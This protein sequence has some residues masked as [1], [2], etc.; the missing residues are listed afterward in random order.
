[1]ETPWYSSCNKDTSS[2]GQARSQRGAGGARAPHQKFEPPPTR[3]CVV[4]SQELTKVPFRLL[5]YLSVSFLCNSVLN[6]S[7]PS[8][9]TTVWSVWTSI[10]VNSAATIWVYDHLTDSICCRGDWD[11]FV[12]PSV[13]SKRPFQL[14]KMMKKYSILTLIF[15]KFSGGIV[16]RNFFSKINVKIAYFSAFLQAEM[17]S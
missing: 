8:L 3:D 12:L 7:F 16:P 17:V 13:W 11:H 9:Q 2:E 5:F 1:M 4:I 14:A 10:I 6:S 15:E